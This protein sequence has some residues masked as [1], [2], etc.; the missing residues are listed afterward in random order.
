M[1]TWDCSVHTVGAEEKINQLTCSRSLSSDWHPSTQSNMKQGCDLTEPWLN[2]GHTSYIVPPASPS[3][4]QLFI[5]TLILSLHANSTSWLEFEAQYCLPIF[6]APTKF[7]LLKA[8]GCLVKHLNLHL[9][10]NYPWLPH[11]SLP[12]EQISDAPEISSSLRPRAQ[13]HA[14]KWS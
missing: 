13:P 11:Q 9:T 10:L 2:P 8:S 3:F 1:A 4:P 7:Y 12:C 5:L 14:D 6:L